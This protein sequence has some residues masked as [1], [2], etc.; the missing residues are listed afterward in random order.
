M[1]LFYANYSKNPKSEESPFDFF[2]YSFATEELAKMYIKRFCGFYILRGYEEK[3]FEVKHFEI[4][5]EEVKDDTIYQVS[6]TTESNEAGCTRLYSKP[7]ANLKDAQMDEMLTT[8]LS[9]ITKHDHYSN[10]DSFH[11]LITGINNPFEY[12]GILYYIYRAELNKIPIIR[13]KKGV[14]KAVSS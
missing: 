1:K 8:A 13:N 3:D 6:I 7:Y 9:I 10:E 12:N 5:D 2:G 14:I 4:N 11:H